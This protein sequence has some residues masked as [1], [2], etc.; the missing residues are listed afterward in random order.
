MLAQRTE[1]YAK[2]VDDVGLLLVDLVAKIKA[3][4]P[5]AELVASEFPNF[6]N[7]VNGIGDIG[8]ELS[9]D[10]AVAIRTIAARMGE[11]IAV[12]LAPGPV[13]APAVTA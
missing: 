1:Q 12:L 7:A 9:A 13:A 8:G 11:L 6:V 3:K 2:E 5:L 4:T 10:Q